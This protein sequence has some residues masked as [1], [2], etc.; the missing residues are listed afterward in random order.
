M[1]SGESAIKTAAGHAAALVRIDQLFN[2]KPGTPDGEELELLI[3]LVERYE[4]TAFP[5]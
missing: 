2:A 1:N 5:I 4:K 3:G